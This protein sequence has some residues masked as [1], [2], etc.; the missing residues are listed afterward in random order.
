MVGANRDIQRL[1][2]VKATTFAYPCREKLNSRGSETASTVP[3]VAKRFLVG[4]GFRD[5][6]ANDPAF[7]DL[8]QVLGVESDGM[9]FEQM[10]QAP[11]TAAK[12]GSWLVFAGH[13]IGAGG[14]QTT[15]TDA[16]QQ[17]LRWANDPASGV[18]L[19]TVQAVARFIQAQRAGK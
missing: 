7:C 15:R 14:Y 11:E 13:E 18:W 8:A 10:K 16:L 5:E 2:G 19:D 1:L 12:D 4:R 6:S 17:F 3:L 9:S